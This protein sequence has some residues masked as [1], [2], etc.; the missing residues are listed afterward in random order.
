MAV[1]ETRIMFTVEDESTNWVQEERSVT[2]LN[3]DTLFE[4]IAIILGHP[5]TRRITRIVRVNFTDL[6][7]EEMKLELINNVLSLSVME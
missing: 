6:T 4:H 3:T 7:I 1:Y 2:S 5:Q